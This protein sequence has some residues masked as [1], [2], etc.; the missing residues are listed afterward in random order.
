M[1]V[2]GYVKLNQCSQRVCHVVRILSRVEINSSK[3]RERLV[4]RANCCFELETE[5]LGNA[6]IGIR[7]GI[8][9]K[10]IITTIHS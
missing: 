10:T 5:F 3:E 2:R 9:S 6:F 8:K 7:V 4:G 1:H